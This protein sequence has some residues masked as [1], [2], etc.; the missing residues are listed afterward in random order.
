MVGS[1]DALVVLLRVRSP[2]ATSPS[3]GTAVC[4]ANSTPGKGIGDL[5]SSNDAP[6]LLQGGV[7]GQRAAHCRAVGKDVN[8]LNVPYFNMLEQRV[9]RPCDGW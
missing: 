7:Q 8:L 6:T 2:R 1:G 4:G 5:G 3:R 9:P